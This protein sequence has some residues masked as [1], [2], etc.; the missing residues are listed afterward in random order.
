MKKFVA[1]TLVAIM[2]I[3]MTAGALAAGNMTLDQAKQ[4]ALDRAGVKAE[5]VQFT[6]AYKDWDDGRTVYELEFWKGNTEY[7]MEVD[8]ATGRVR[9]YDA[10]RHGYDFDDDFDYDFDDAFDHDFDDAFDDFFDWF[11]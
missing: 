7:D 4:A 9:D 2:A 3:L 11:D 8:A 6:K 1:A 10:D 5:E